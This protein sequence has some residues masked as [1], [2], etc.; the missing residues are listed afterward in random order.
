MLRPNWDGKPLD[1]AYTGDGVMVNSG[2][3][4]GLT[5]K[6]GVARVTAY[7]EEKGIGERKVNYK[8]RDWLISRQRYWG[9]PIPII[10]CP[11]CGEVAVP[12]D[13]LPVLLP[14]VEAYEPTGDGR[15][16][17]A[18]V[19]DWVNTTCPTCGGPALRETDT[20][21]GF[22]CSSWYF[23]RFASPRYDKAFA[24]PSALKYWLP[25]DLYV[26][27]TEHAVMHLLFARFWTKVMYDAGAGALQE[28][29]SKL[30]NQGM[31]LAVDGQ[32]MSKSRPQTVVTPEIVVERFGADAVRCYE[33][34]MGPFDQ[35]V[36]WDEKGL[37]GVYRFLSRIWEI[38]LADDAGKGKGA[39]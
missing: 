21:G 3:F 8:M 15:S 19:A 39:A 32:K 7:M 30:M 28:P 10:H 36:Q 12:E 9:A 4:N 14:D 23:M 33:M 11:H 38:T 2:P 26:G 5:G 27:G 31:L 1:A 16:P 29:F 25:V 13:Q 35:E 37:A 34:F 20:M 22:A 17:L 24:E 6:E 18:N